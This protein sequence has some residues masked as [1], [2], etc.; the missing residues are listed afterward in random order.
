MIRRSILVALFALCATASQ[1]A[2][3]TW[4][5]PGDGSNT[6]TTGSPNCDTIAQAVVAASAGDSVAVA[7]GS[8]PV[9]ASIAVN[10]QLTIT[11]AGKASTTVAAS[12]GIAAFEIRADG[13]VIQDLTISG[14]T[15]GVRFPVASSTTALT[16]IGLSAQTGNNVDVSTGPATPVSAV[17]ISDGT[18]ASPGTIGVR[19]SSNST[20]NGLAITGSTFTGSSY[21]IYGANDGNTSTLTN[22]SVS[23]CT[24]TNP[25]NSYAI[26][27]EEVTAGAIEDSTFTGGDN[28]IGIL[29]FY[30]SNA[31]A[32]AN[33]GIRRNQF[34]GFTGN[35]LDVEMIGMGLGSPG[36]A[37]EDNTITKG[38][39]TLTRAAGAFVRL[40]PTQ[41]NGQ[42][43]F[44]GNTITATGT[45]GSGTAVHGVQLRGN[46][47]VAFTDNLIDGGNVGGSAVNPPSSG[48]FIQARSGSV[49]MPATTV[50]TGGCNRIRNFHHGVSVFDSFANAYGGLPVGAT[51]S[52]E[53]NAIEDNDLAQVA[54]GAS[55]TLDFEND[56]WGCQAGCDTTTGAVDTTPALTAPPACVACTADADCDDGLFCTGAETC[57]AGTC[58]VPGDP[59]AG[60]DQCGNVCNETADDCVVPDGTAC[61]DGEVCTV[62]DQCTA[63][64]C[65]G[66]SPCG[67]GTTEGTCGELCDD[68][69]AVSNDGCS[70]TCQPEFVCTPTPLVGCKTAESGKSQ[71]QLKDKTPGTPDAKDQSQWKYG[72]GAITP[73]S[74]FGNPAIATD[75]QFCIY[76]GGTLVS[77]AFIP[78][79]GTCA[80]KACWKENSKGFQYKDKDA[81]PDGVTQLK[82]KEGLVAGK[83]QIQLKGKGANLDMP[84]LPLAQPVVVQIRNTNGVC[85]ETT[86]SAPAGK[87]DVTQ[88]KDKND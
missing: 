11:G 18:F 32:I 50:I 77:R 14:G 55:P 60:G 31:T 6:C 5:V 13:I 39:G 43:D 20:V 21:G 8:F 80:G 65:G 12:A 3:T 54:N 45:F 56:W 37:I 51:V 83:A 7:A 10:K 49:I 78:A 30:A 16:R 81:T 41:P 66:G 40:H 47:P 71:L 82:L 69:N 70:A 9:A 17:T 48:I 35:A 85:W 72:K 62:D 4:L 68:G 58:V 84:S 33:V 79:A 76:A 42:V 26:Y 63:G 87:N 64:V 73:K 57:N 34:S 25:T 29:K 86:H 28:G 52:F 53:N 27:L 44:T 23:G 1:A 46:G 75:Y 88:F 15:T 61:D 36:I 22:F 24:F 19:L 74:D 59:C 2:A 67:N 38:V